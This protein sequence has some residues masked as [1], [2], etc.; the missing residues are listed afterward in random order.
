MSKEYEKCEICGRP[1]KA[2]NDDPALSTF[3]VCSKECL[4]ELTSLILPRTSPGTDNLYREE[5][6]ALK[7]CKDPL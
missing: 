7:N 3:Q 6:T 1:I 4:E 5:S 2:Y